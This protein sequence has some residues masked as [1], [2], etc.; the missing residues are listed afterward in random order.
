MTTF[1]EAL[2][3]EFQDLGMDGDPPSPRRGWAANCPGCGRFCKSREHHYYDGTWNQIALIT[4]CAQCGEMT[5][6]LV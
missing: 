1:R 4:Y 5:T 6:E 2:D 3:K